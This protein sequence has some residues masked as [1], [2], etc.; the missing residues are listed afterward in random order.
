M[1]ANKFAQYHAIMRRTAEYAS[2]L[3]E[4]IEET[5]ILAAQLKRKLDRLM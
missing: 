5:Q 3:D 1:I 2:V 4:D